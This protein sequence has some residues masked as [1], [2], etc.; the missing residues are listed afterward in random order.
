[1]EQSAYLFPSP[2]SDRLKT[3][4]GYSG[5]VSTLIGW[6]RPVQR[7]VQDGELI[8]GQGISPAARRSATAAS[9]ELAYRSPAVPGNKSA[10]PE[11]CRN[12]RALNATANTS[13]LRG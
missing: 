9:S 13:L 7:S 8:H 11:S 10:W 1:V 3:Q 5:D 4:V 12:L 2:A 6:M